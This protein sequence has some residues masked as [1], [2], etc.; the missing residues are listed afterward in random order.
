MSFA[1]LAMSVQPFGKRDVAALLHATERRKVHIDE[2]DEKYVSA[3]Q[4]ATTPVVTDKKTA[5]RGVGGGTSY[6]VTLKLCVTVCISDLRS[7]LE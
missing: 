2:R 4:S 5:A 6:A 3:A 1:T 7:C